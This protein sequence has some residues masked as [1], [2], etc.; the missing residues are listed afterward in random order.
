[1]QVG[2]AYQYKQARKKLQST[3][4]TVNVLLRTL[5]NKVAPFAFSPVAVQM[6]FASPPQQRYDSYADI[7]HIANSTTRNIK[8]LAAVV[9]AAAAAKLAG[10]W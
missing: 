2:Y 1:M 3:A 4:W 8:A 7:M 10:L 5:L 9:V 6:L